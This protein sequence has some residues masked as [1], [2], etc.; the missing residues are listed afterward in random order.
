MIKQERIKED[1]IISGVNEGARTLVHG[2][3][4]EFKTM[5]NLEEIAEIFVKQTPILS[6]KTVLQLIEANWDRIEYIKKKPEEIIVML[7]SIGFLGEFIKGDLLIKQRYT[8]PTY[9]LMR[10]DQTGEYYCS[11]FSF[12]GYNVDLSKAD[13]LVIAPVFWDE[14]KIDVDVNKEY[15]IYSTK[16]EGKKEAKVISRKY[17]TVEI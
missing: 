5:P 6:Y 10:S 15:L 1:D 12:A 2:L 9:P 11:L 13:E 16:P 4:S 17:K 14:L 8:I 7:Y 3:F